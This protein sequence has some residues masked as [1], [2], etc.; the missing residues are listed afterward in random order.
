MRLRRATWQDATPQTPEEAERSMFAAI[1]A[2]GVDLA[3]VRYDDF[4][5]Q[6]A[7]RCHLRHTP[8]D[9]ALYAD[10]DAD[11]VPDAFD[12][13]PH[14]FNPNQYDFDLDGVGDCCDRDIDNDGDPNRLDPAPFD[15]AITSGYVPLA[16]RTL[17]NAAGAVTTLT[18]MSL[19]WVLDAR[20]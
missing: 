18:A 16:A 17:Y 8:V 14:C 20:G 19:G 10:A 9:D 2:P 12:N 6:P 4:R 5:V 3:P 7:Y 1:G 11:G 15:P 13:C